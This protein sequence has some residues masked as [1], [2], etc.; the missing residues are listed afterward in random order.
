MSHHQ[1]QMDYCID[2]KQILG[3]S[4][5]SLKL[6][7]VSGQLT[8]SNGQKIIVALPPNSSVDLSE[9]KEKVKIGI[10]TMLQIIE[11]NIIY[12]KKNTTEM[13]YILIRH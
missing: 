8:V 2:F 11:K 4:E 10:I 7:P 6:V 5:Q 9:Y 3:I 13:F 1:Y 12:I